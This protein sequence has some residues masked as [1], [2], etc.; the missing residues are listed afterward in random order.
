M[1]RLLEGFDLIVNFIGLGVASRL[2]L[3][4]A[5]FFLLLGFVDLY[6]QV[7]TDLLQLGLVH[8]LDGIDKLAAVSQHLLELQLLYCL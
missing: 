4:E 2:G 7:G 1:H 3:N 5:I 8:A 6:V